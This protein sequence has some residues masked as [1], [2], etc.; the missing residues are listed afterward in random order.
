M[1][2]TRVYLAGNM[3][4]TSDCNSWRNYVKSEMAKMGVVTLSPL[5]TTFY[6]QRSETDEDRENLKSRREA[7]LYDEVHE[8]MRGVIQKDLRLIDISDFIIINLEVD[9][10]T[11]GTI[12]ELVVAT[13]QKKPIFLVVKDKKRTP[14]W[15]LGLIKPKYIYESIDDVMNKIRDI[16][17]GSHRM[18][19]EKWRLL[20]ADLR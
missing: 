4:C 14:L 5:E 13:Q 10:P 6:N 17:S 3:E 16:D 18:D 15:L 19:S 20:T 1:N 12:H 2:H 7:G 11:F 8:Y 9:K